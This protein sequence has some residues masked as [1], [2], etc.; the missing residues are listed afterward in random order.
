MATEECPYNDLMQDISVAVV[1]GG[2]WARALAQRLSHNREGLHGR[3]VHLGHISRVMRY[4]PPADLPRIASFVAPP[5]R[6]VKAPVPPSAR[7]DGGDATVQISAD[8]LLFAAGELYGDSIELGELVE[9]NLII[10]AV[11]AAKVKPLLETMRGVLHDKQCL[12]HA[13]GSFAPTL[14]AGN[15][16]LKPIS[17]LVVRET[18][19]KKL[20]AIAGPALAEDLEEEIPAAVACGSP[21]PEVTMM[22]QTAM[23]C[24]L[25]RVYPTAD[26]IGVEAARALVGVMALACGVADSLGLGPSVRAQLVAAGTAEMA[27]LGVVLGGLERTFWGAAGAGELIVA[28]ER[29]GAPDFQLGRLLGQGKSLGDASR[30]IDRACDGLNMVREAHNLAQRSRL[31]LPI[32]SALYRW[33]SGKMDLRSSM[34]ELLERELRV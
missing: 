8:A 30:Q 23:H 24:S 11:P 18:P 7:S 4:Q 19:I 13:I 15:Q 31:S 16:A 29:R 2:R 10:L 27:Q 26:L 3:I 17:E 14:E 25:L 1:G 28:T 9:A 5:E 32:V 21:S 20:G 34:T 33:V 22:V 6:P 12:V